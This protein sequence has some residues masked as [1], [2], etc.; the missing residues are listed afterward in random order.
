[1]LA[2][3]G[4]TRPRLLLS[5]AYAG[6]SGRDLTLTWTAASG[7]EDAFPRQRLSARCRLSQGTFAGTRG[8]G[9][10]AP[11]PDLHAAAPEK[12]SSTPSRPDSGAKHWPQELYV[13]RLRR[14]RPPRRRDLL[15]DRKRQAQRS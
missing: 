11:T 8:N 5:V 14:R 13:C 12:G 1:M 10:D 2:R 9:R 4:R 3:R 7:P 6:Y 15:A